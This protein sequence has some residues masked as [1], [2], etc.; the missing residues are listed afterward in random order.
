MVDGRQFWAAVAIHVS[1]ND[2]AADRPLTLLTQLNCRPTEQIASLYATPSGVHALLIGHP[3]CTGAD[4][5]PHRP[6]SNS[7]W[8][9]HELALWPNKPQEQ[10]PPLHGPTLLRLLFHPVHLLRGA[11]IAIW[12][13][14]FLISATSATS[15]LA[16][17]SEA[18]ILY[19]YVVGPKISDRYIQVC[20]PNRKV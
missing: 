10:K 17:W 20:Y 4:W 1:P 12:L 9:C 3:R 18:R 8:V 5:G 19:I 11:S 7:C 6:S 2:P 13:N 14:S 15:Q 16:P